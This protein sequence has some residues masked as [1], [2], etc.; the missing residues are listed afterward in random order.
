MTR[1]LVLL[2]LWQQEEDSIAEAPQLS[3]ETGE[4][5]P[6]NN[7][8]LKVQHNILGT[9]SSCTRRKRKQICGWCTQCHVSSFL[10]LMKVV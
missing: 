5:K 8:R 7:K 10:D 4:K 3:P 9:I 6:N 2:L 1:A